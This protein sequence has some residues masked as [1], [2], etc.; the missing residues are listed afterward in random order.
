MHLPNFTQTSDLTSIIF[1]NVCSFALSWN[2][3]RTCR[4]W[5]RKDDKV[6]VALCHVI[7]EDQVKIQHTCALY[8]FLHFLLLKN[9]I[10]NHLWQSAG[11]WT[12]QNHQEL[13]TF[14]AWISHHFPKFP[15]HTHLQI[16]LYH[17]KMQNFQWISLKANFNLQV[18]VSLLRRSKFIF[19]M[20]KP[21]EVIP[22]QWTVHFRIEY[23]AS[24]RDT[25]MTNWHSNVNVI[26]HGI[27][28]RWIKYLELYQ[29]LYEYNLRVRIQT[30]AHR[31]IN[32]H[33][34]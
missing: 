29:T 14:L 28:G 7:P 2:L 20:Y 18:W 24:Y 5:P 6:S 31:Y 16:Q 19:F 30:A 33:S 32:E 8:S 4:N 9:E 3:A 10:T 27:D 23:L 15:P 12:P 21:I 25:Y 34:H 11:L 13:K 22:G 1:Y 26:R 17:I